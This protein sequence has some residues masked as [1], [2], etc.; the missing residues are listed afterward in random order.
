VVHICEGDLH[1]DLMAEILKHGTIKVLGVIHRDLLRNS[2][3]T[4][5]VLPENFWMVVE[6]ILVTGFTSTHL[7][8]YSTATMAKV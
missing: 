3:A 4:D 5:D 2:V 8:K 7:V 6:D 1:S